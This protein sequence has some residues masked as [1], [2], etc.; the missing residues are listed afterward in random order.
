VIR[1]ITKTAGEGGSRGYSGYKPYSLLLNGW[2][3]WIRIG[4]DLRDGVTVLMNAAV[5]VE[6]QLLRI[7][8]SADQTARTCC[9][10]SAAPRAREKPAG[11]PGLN[12]QKAGE[13]YWLLPPMMTAMMSDRPLHSHVRRFPSREAV[14]PAPR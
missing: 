10:D 5:N 2:I 1:C 4:G 12:G 14:H 11:R 13:R 3:Y 6:G 8:P 7:K 9:T